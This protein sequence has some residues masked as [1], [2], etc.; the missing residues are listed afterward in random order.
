MIPASSPFR[1]FAPMLGGL[2]SVQL[3]FLN[4]EGQQRT[5]DGPLADDLDEFAA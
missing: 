3:V 1:S 4:P 2:M 5:R